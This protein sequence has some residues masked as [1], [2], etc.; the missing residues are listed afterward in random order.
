MDDPWTEAWAEAEAS[1]PPGVLIYCTLELRHP[2]FTDGV[3]PF[4]VRAVSGVHED[5]DF[6]LEDEAVVDGGDTV[7]FKA[8]PFFADPPEFEEGKTPESQ[9]TIDNVARELIPYLEQAVLL[10]ADLTA[11]YR[12]YRS[13]DLTGPCYGP[14]TFIVKQVKVTGTRVQGM[15]RIDDLAN[16]KFP[17]KVYTLDAFPGLRT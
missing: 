9:I 12:E 4:A 16:R 5:M 6:T 15:A 14:V 8:V 7:T 17:N 10:R 2:A 13:D 11:T 3:T 1:A